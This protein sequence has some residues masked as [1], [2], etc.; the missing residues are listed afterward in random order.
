MTVVIHYAKARD[1]WPR[2]ACGTPARAGNARF[3][4]DLASVD[5]EACLASDEVAAQRMENALEAKQL[6]PI[7]EANPAPKSWEAYSRKHKLK[8]SYGKSFTPPH[9]KRTR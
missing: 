7:E 5:C 1:H 6:F 2:P 9:Q 8:R 4:D 3:S